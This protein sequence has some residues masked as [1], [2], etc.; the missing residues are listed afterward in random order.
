MANAQFNLGC[1]YENGDGVAQDY[2]EALRFYKLAAEQG[3][4]IAEYNLG[5]MYVNGYG[6]ARDTAE[7]IRWFERAAAKGD[8][9]AIQRL[10]GLRR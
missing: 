5:C 9:D 4:T 2:A 6:V 8:E 1:C 7:A 3:F 10:A